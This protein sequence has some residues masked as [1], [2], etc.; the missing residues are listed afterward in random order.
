MA[1]P[2]SACPVHAPAASPL[3]T[4]SALALQSTTQLGR[5]P[6]VRQAGVAPKVQSAFVSQR[7]ARQSPST[8]AKFCGYAPGQPVALA[9][10]QSA[11]T[12]QR[13]AQ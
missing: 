9:L 7:G 4:Q 2:S 6:S 12:T 1:A 13:F 5:P 3:A 11:A 10:Q 8:Q